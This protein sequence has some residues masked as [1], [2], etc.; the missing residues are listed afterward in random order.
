MVYPYYDRNLGQWKKGT[1]TKTI[2]NTAR[3]GA[4]ESLMEERLQTGAN[5]WRKGLFEERSENTDGDQQMPD[6]N[7]RSDAPAKWDMIASGKWMQKAAEQ[8]G[9]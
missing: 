9:D 5:K 6:Q 7:W 1:W 3:R 4:A 8:M 2:R